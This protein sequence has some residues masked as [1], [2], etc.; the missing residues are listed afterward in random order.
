MISDPRKRPGG[1]PTRIP[2]RISRL[3]WAL[4]LLAVAA[5][6]LDAGPAAASTAAC[7]GAMRASAPAVERRSMLCLVNRVRL[8]RGLPPL[9]ESRALDRSALLRAREIRRC[10]QFSHTACGQPF[11]RVFARAGYRGGTY[12]ENLAWG[13]SRLGSPSWTLGAWLRSPPHRSN[14]YRPGWRDFGVALV[15]ARRLF[16]RPDVSLWVMQ[17]GV[18]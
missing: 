12:A 2:S 10:R 17:F 11:G 4:F 13:M 16:G 7:A 14:L 18:T 6:A 1:D 5:P 15:R 9:R 8:E 3:L